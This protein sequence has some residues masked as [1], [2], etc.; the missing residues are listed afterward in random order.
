MKSGVKRYQTALCG[1][2]KNGKKLAVI[3]YYSDRDD[4]ASVDLHVDLQSF[5]TYEI[6]LLDKDHNGELIKTVNDLD[7]T[8]SLHS[9]VLIKEI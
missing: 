4:L 1:V 6:Y 2:N 7:I 8:V 3:A 5:G 9:V